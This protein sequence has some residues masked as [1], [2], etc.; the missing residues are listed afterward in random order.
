MA[1][2]NFSLTPSSTDSESDANVWE[3]VT[4]IGGDTKHGALQS[5]STGR[6]LRS[7][8]AGDDNTFGLSGGSDIPDDAV[9]QWLWLYIVWGSSVVNEPMAL[10]IQLIDGSDSSVFDTT[11]LEL[12]G[13]SNTAKVL[14][15]QSQGLYGI[16]T[17]SDGSSTAWTKTNMQ[18]LKVRLE[19]Q[20]N[21]TT[22]ND[23]SNFLEI[24]NLRVDVMCKTTFPGDFGTSNV[25]EN[26]MG[27]PIDMKNGTLNIKNGVVKVK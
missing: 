1:S 26:N 23:T 17:T 7:D 11:G 10:N 24:M 8:T 18:N 19:V 22:D 21:S 20:D 25:Y 5:T 13:P 9:I 14:T 2:Q 4:T 6:Y 15:T 3:L 16:K 12:I 27:S